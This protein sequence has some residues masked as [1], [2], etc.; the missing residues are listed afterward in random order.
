M[1]Y[2][3]IIPSTEITQIDVYR[4][5]V[6]GAWPN[7]ATI[8]TIPGFNSTWRY[9]AGVA[10]LGRQYGGGNGVLRRSFFVIDAQRYVLGQY[11]YMRR[12]QTR[13]IQYGTGNLWSL[14][15]TYGALSQ[16]VPLSN[17]QNPGDTACYLLG[18]NSPGIW[19]IP[20]TPSS[21]PSWQDNI[22]IKAG[23]DVPFVSFYASVI[24]KVFR[25][26]P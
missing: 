16:D 8:M 19:M 13:L 18:T 21:H 1:T 26:V 2:I 10:M 20:Y 24:I 4:A 9:I 23:N 15:D 17:V 25:E 11:H 6:T 7:E 22:Q 12:V 14:G 3:P 5:H